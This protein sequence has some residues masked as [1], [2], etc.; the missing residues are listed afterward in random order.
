M[1]FGMR[2]AA[3][4]LAFMSASRVSLP[5]RAGDDGQR[6]SG[7]ESDRFL[8]R[9][10]GLDSVAT[11]RLRSSTTNTARSSCRRKWSCRLQAQPHL[12]IRIGP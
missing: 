1:S 11:N 9:S 7:E 8:V 4:G 6:R 3:V 5:A 12:W 2:S 10:L